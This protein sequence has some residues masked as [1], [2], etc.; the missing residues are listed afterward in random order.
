PITTKNTSRLKE[1]STLISVVFLLF[2]FLLITPS[3]G[4]AMPLKS[5]AAY[6]VVEAARTL[7]ALYSIAT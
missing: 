2:I 3:G 7:V 4:S 6:H 5:L 1:K